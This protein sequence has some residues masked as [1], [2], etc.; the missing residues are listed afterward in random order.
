MLENE[1]VWPFGESLAFVGLGEYGSKIH[2]EE[3]KN[4]KVKFK[5]ILFN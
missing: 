5:M 4:F 3:Y 1:V 2:L